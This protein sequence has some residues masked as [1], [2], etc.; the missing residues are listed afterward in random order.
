VFKGFGQTPWQSFDFELKL[1]FY[2]TQSAS[3][4]LRQFLQLPQPPQNMTLASKVVKTYLKI[5]ISPAVNFINV[6][7]G[8]ILAQKIY[9]A[10]HN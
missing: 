6:L 5:I 10:E 8:E 3:K 2:T 9:K 7:R 4:C 1:T